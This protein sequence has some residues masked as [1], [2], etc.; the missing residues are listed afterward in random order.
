MVIFEC[1]AGRREWLPA[2]SDLTGKYSVRPSPRD[3][4][5][6]RFR[7]SRFAMTPMKFGAGGCCV[8]SGSTV[9]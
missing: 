9:S 8:K 4:V 5:V 3:A 6:S 7:H 1:M 2:S